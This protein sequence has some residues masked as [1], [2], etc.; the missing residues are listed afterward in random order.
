MEWV[1]Q[2][3]NLFV[4]TFF[5]SEPVFSSSSYNINIHISSL[6]EI[7]N[8]QPHNYILFCR[9]DDD[10]DQLQVFFPS[11]R[12]FVFF[13]LKGARFTPYVQLAN[14]SYFHQKKIEYSLNRR[15]TNN[16]TKK[17]KNEAHNQWWILGKKNVSL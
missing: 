11:L 8:N 10:D 5:R 12:V 17:E 14:Y 2:T 15:C 16:N 13:W 1:F 6:T 3:C 9:V 7:R 4:S